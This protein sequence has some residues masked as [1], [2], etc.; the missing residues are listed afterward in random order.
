MNLDLYLSGKI[1]VLF[2]PGSNVF[3]SPG[4]NID[5]SIIMLCYIVTISMRTVMLRKIIAH[6]RYMVKWI[7]I[8]VNSIFLK[9]F[10]FPKW[11]A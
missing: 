7:V 8:Q 10:M 1:W 2:V 3:R 5:D 9:N 6:N 11:H 4:E